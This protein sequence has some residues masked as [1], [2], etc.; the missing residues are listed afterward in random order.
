MSSDCT[1]ACYYFPNYHVD[2]RNEKQ[3]GTGWSEWELVR[4]A[5]PRFLSVTSRASPSGASRMRPIRG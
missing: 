5:E 3:H 1:V 4:R 2:P